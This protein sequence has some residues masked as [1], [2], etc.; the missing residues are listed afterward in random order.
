MPSGVGIRRAATLSY[1][2]RHWN[3]RH[4]LT[5][6]VF[7]DSKEHIK[8]IE[9]ACD[10]PPLSSVRAQTKS[11]TFSIDPIDNRLR[12]YIVCDYEHC[13]TVSHSGS[14]EGNVGLDHLVYPSPKC[15]NTM[16]DTVNSH[17]THKHPDLFVCM[18]PIPDA[19]RHTF[20][21][22]TA[23]LSNWLRATL[24]FP[25][26]AP[27]SSKRY[28]LWLKNR[29]CQS[30]AATFFERWVGPIFPL[31]VEQFLFLSCLNGPH[32]ATL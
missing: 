5:R 19:A 30:S 3:L 13:S 12:F 21:R 23:G 26:T 4:E 1:A 20:C 2:G 8:N 14:L 17:S 27:N 22:I 18:I 29:I 16:L 15:P 24:S 25:T 28:K 11:A 7:I 10:F 32:T 9:R 31:L 6:I